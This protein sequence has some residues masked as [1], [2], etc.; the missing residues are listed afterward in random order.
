MFI[1][2][3]EIGELLQRIVGEADVAKERGANDWGEGASWA[4]SQ[5]RLGLDRISNRAVTINEAAKISG[6]S[7]DHLRRLVREGKLEEV[8][9][10]GVMRV[11]VG[12]LPR[13]AAP[14]IAPKDEISD[15]W[16]SAMLAS[17]IEE[18]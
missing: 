5:V 2:E 17:V 7:A 18:E 3:N 15:C 13:K 10:G 9:T 14:R 1:D 4:T 6:F 8:G 12:D 16:V 11:R